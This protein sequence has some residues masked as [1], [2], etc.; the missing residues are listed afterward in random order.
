MKATETRFLDFLNGPKQYIIPIYQRTYSWTAKQCLQL[1]KD[2]V[3]TG[4]HD[5][6]AG[7]F[8]G[9]IVYIQAGLFQSS[10][11]PQLL[12]IDGQQRLA[13]LSLLLSA[14]G[15]A[16]ENSPTPIKDITRPEIEGFYLFNLLGRGELKYK[17]LLT[18]SD[19]PTLIQLLE[20][21]HLPD[22]ASQRIV[23]NY[24]FFEEQIAKM[25]PPLLG[26]DGLMTLY[27]GINKLIVVDISLDRNYDNP[28]LIFESINSTGLELSQA[29][30]I[31]NYVLMGLEPSRQEELYNDYWYPMEQSFGQA[32]YS[33]LFDRF[34]RDYLTIKTGRIPNIQQVY[35]AFKTYQANPKSGTIR[36]LVA[37][38][39]RYS[40]YFARMALE[41]EPDAEL[42]RC[43][44][45]INTL[46][47]EVAYP[48]L[49]EV[50]DDYQQ[51]RLTRDEFIRVVRLVES[52][53]FRRAVCGI[54]TNSLNKTF[55]TLGREV[56][57]RNYV[58]SFEAALALM[59]SYRR[60][61]D[62]GEFTREMVI[63][64]L[65]NFRS[66]SY[67]LRKLEN[68]DRKE[69]VRIEEYTVEHVM[70]QNEDLSPDWQA[71]LGDDWKQVHARYLHTLGNLTLTGYNP[72][73]SDRPF[74]AKRDMKGGFADSPIR[75]N[76]G[77]AKLEHW[78]ES[79]IQARAAELAELATQVW[80]YPQ[81]P[82]DVLD[83]YRVGG[84]S[85]Q[86]AYTLADHPQL[87]G[88]V[89]DLFELFRRRV[90]ALDP[91]VTEE[92]LKY[93]IAYKTTTNFVDVVPQKSRLLLMLNMAFDEIQDPKRLCRD[94]TGI[95][96]WGNGD[97]EVRLSSPAQLD[98]VMDLVRQSFTLHTDNGDE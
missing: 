36:E 43:F 34:M 84:R 44:A 32:S 40:R 67:W 76:R 86:K 45:D 96:R 20:S 2:I 73:L 16:I 82:T 74:R 31:R 5:D 50:Y 89:R 98:D 64:D 3:R 52:Y 35:E 92:V 61:P 60:F 57:K 12:V 51:Q 28:Q 13:T 66:R 69:C 29:D 37:D 41:T 83:S 77:L 30:L 9:S 14:L 80:A 8:I 90:I 62:N 97:I 39:Y 75:L 27:R 78:N 54:P 88:E 65:Y 23:E 38:V 47:V 68:H 46:R 56:D 11:I 21:K 49:L 18:Q 7:H 10:A 95:G 55:A 26:S 91:A 71:E 33:R 48:L 87:V 70:P 17:L 15:R 58:E 25:S 93:Y 85:K 42:C 81:L 94:V 1:W 63:K 59:R 19:K 72:E 4:Q 79:T 6:I 24:R 53:V 22:S